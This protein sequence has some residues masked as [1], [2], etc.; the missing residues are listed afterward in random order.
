MYYQIELGLFFGSTKQKPS[1]VTYCCAGKATNQISSCEGKAFE[2][3]PRVRPYTAAAQ[4]KSEIMCGMAIKELEQHAIDDVD[5]DVDLMEV[6]T[7][8]KM[9]NTSVFGERERTWSD[10]KKE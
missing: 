9:T 7:I 2:K 6:P 8:Q 4:H 5:F 3:R 1:H 10:E